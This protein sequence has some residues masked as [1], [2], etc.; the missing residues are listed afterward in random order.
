MDT[1]TEG[2]GDGTIEAEGELTIASEFT[3][4]GA[5]VPDADEIDMPPVP[6]DGNYD[7]SNFGT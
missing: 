3:S 4:Q 1:L 2:N 5:D 6:D 7:C